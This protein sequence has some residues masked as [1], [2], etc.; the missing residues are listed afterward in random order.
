MFEDFFAALR[1]FQPVEEITVID[2]FSFFSNFILEEAA[3]HKLIE[4]LAKTASL[5]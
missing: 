2:F 5:V 3:D 1:N 4:R